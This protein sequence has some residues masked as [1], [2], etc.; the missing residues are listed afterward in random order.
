M[1]LGEHAVLHQ[2]HALVC[3]IDK[4]VHVELR[5]RKDDVVMIQSDLG[6]Y[7][8]RLCCIR[9]EPPFSFVLQAIVDRSDR[10]QTGFDLKITSEMSPLFG[11][12]TSA[13]VTAATTACLLQT[14]HG[15][16]DLMELFDAT[17]HTVRSVQG[18]GSG[19]DIA[20]SIFGGCVL[21]RMEPKVI[22]ILNPDFGL[23]VFYCGYKMKTAE[24]IQLVQKKR[25]A[26]TW[27]FDDFFTIIDRLVL[28]GA[29]A[30]QKGSMRDL[31]E[32]FNIQQGLMDAM[33]LSTK[34]LSELVHFLRKQPDIHGAKISGSGLGDSV[35][36]LGK[37]CQEFEPYK[38]LPIH[39]SQQGLLF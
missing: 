18:R 2:K 32:L 26:R 21:Y 3:A 14:I 6:A 27:L 33:G 31:G 10:L 25:D 28:E 15:H 12:G 7:A 8:T 30:I 34:E 29:D 23:R 37:S 38:S 35:I 19:A 5:A 39:T 20:A 9:P 24:V 4:R 17:C 11:L 16:C 1:L 36:G 22:K 13:A